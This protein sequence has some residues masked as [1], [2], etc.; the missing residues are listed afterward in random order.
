MFGREEYMKK[1]GKV[2]R[3]NNRE[4]E[5]ERRKRRKEYFEQYRKK[6]SENKRE[7]DKQY[8]E[9]HY[10]ER[11]RY[12]VNKYKTDI[13][14]NLNKRMGYSMRLALKGNKNG[15]HWE[16]LVPYNFIQLK[17][18]LQKTLPKNYTWQDFL[19]GKL[20]VDHIIPISAHNFN[21]PNQTDFQRCW[22]LSNLRLLPAKENISK[23]NKLIK[24]FQLSLKICFP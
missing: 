21:S 3:K 15:K 16:N 7:Y 22:A 19:E 23:G 24:S 9:C 13:K 18:H 12:L 1:Y 14:F 5:K 11:N 4:K 8:R 17:N 6:N 20:H 2:Y 10:I